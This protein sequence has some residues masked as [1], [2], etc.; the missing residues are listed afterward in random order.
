MVREYSNGMQRVLYAAVLLLCMTCSAGTEDGLY[1]PQAPDYE[2]ATCW[3]TR[4]DDA[5]GKGAD[6]FYLVS[7]WEADWR[8]DDGRL[9]RY[10]D[11]YNA[12]HRAHMEQEKAMQP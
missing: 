1:V 6:V 11:V 12:E 9:C 4:M 7:T 10:A 2:D 3:F 5:T 8:T